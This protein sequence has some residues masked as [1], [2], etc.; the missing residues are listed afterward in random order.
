MEDAAKKHPLPSPIFPGT[1][2]TLFDRKK[3]PN[4]ARLR[5]PQTPIKA[6]PQQSKM[7]VAPKS[8]NSNLESTPA[9]R[10]EEG[11]FESIHPLSHG[12][13]GQVFSCRK[14][15]KDYACKIMPLTGSGKVYR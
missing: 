5:P 13:F 15:G 10:L 7:V 14:G 6:T 2:N 11:G 12:S 4:E 3:T 1:D 8:T 9:R